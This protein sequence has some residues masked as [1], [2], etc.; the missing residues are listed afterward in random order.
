MPS[1][2]ISDRRTW[3]DPRIRSPLTY[4]PLV[5]PRSSRMYPSARTLSRQCCPEIVGCAIT[6]SHSG[7][8]PTSQDG[9][10]AI[11]GLPFLTG[12]VRRAPESPCTIPGGRGS[13]RAHSGSGSDGASP[14]QDQAKPFSV[15]ALTTR[16]LRLSAWRSSSTP[17]PCRGRQP[18]GVK[19]RVELTFGRALPLGGDKPEIIPSP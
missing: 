19:P 1:V 5:E 15:T 16:L 8:L 14:S 7:A 12:H 3:T 10:F 2:M 17:R 9:C 13:V 11:A 6:T 4:V 18:R